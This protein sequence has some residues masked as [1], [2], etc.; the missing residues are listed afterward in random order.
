MKNENV[1]KT[2]EVKKSQGK[3]KNP[4]IFVRMG[5]KLK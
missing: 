5:R 1:T 4:N 3:Q 2:V